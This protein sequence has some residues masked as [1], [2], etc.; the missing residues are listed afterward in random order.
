[1]SGSSEVLQEYLIKLGYNVDQ[2]SLG[3]FNAGISQ[4]GKNIMRVGGAVA[5]V[6]ASIE[7]STIAFAYSMRKV[8]FQSQ[9]TESSVANLKSLS[10]ASRQVGLD[11]E[12]MGNAVQH[13]A[14]MMRVNPGTQQ[15][16][17]SF[18][19]RVS[20][21]DTSDVAKDL[22][23]VL[24]QMPEFVGVQWAQQLLGM[25]ADSFHLAIKNLD[26]L[27]AKQR[28][29]IGVYASMGLSQEDAAK[30]MLHYAETVD[31][32]G[33]R[34]KTLGAVFMTEFAPEFDAVNQ[35]VIGAIDWW[36]DWARGI[37]KVSDLFKN[38]TIKDIS[39]LLKDAYG[40]SPEDAKAGKKKGFWE[41]AFSSPADQ[42]Q[43]SG[44]A[45]PPAPNSPPKV[46]TQPVAPSTSPVANLPAAVPQ[47]AKPPTAAPSKGAG[48]LFA[49]LE[50]KHELP[51]GLL[52]RVW[53][54]E[55]GRGKAM[56]S[57]AGAQGHF[58]FMPKTASQYG[59]S[60]PNDLAQSAS[61][62]AKMYAN[63]L[64]K[65]GG[66]IQKALI[67]YNWGEGNLDSYMK[68]GKGLPK[69]G[70]AGTGLPQE[71]RDYA[72]KISGTPLGAQLLSP[73][74]NTITTTITVNGSNEPKDTAREIGRELSRVNQDLLR[75]GVVRVS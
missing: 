56:L 58:G 2:I 24:K 3:K 48:E 29:A 21:R 34:L 1:M 61:G 43:K 15:L 67:A 17:E 40:Q 66:D 44:A 20:G 36:A 38:L 6:A 53:S 70:R 52:D 18:G 59:V 31:S 13:M 45:S 71:S 46:A 28:E 39:K 74:N 30:Q 19:V 33:L 60:D 75:N 35:L 10:F 37:N 25:D 51:A 22:L 9:L 4:S 26:Q 32:L 16:I 69:N 5:A 41:W 49:S 27:N 64:K 14:R 73:V 11:S 23:G 72:E 12:A 42:A 57:P 7:A 47:A 50:Q 63:L 62:A 8:Y 54:K 68:T 55:S 65:Y